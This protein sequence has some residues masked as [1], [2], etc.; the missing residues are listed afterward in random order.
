M[1]VFHFYLIRWNNTPLDDAI[2]HRNKEIP[3][4]PQYGALTKVIDILREHIE[5]WDLRDNNELVEEYCGDQYDA[6]EAMIGEIKE[7]MQGISHDIRNI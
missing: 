1:V 5:E 4:S 7:K 2:S 3:H 6:N